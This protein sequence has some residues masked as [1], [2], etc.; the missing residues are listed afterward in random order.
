MSADTGRM[1]KA[2]AETLE[3]LELEPK[4]AGIAALSRELAGL[5]DTAAAGGRGLE[6]YHKLAPR[7]AGVLR[8]LGATPASSGRRGGDDPD[9]G[10]GDDPAA[11]ELDELEQRRR[12]RSDRAADMD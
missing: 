8:E 12:T 6:A 11:R 3:A 1:G 9:D 2:V 10:D 7:L 5:L 4:H